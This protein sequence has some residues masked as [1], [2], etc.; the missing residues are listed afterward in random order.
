MWID[1]G[2]SATISLV[3]RQAWLGLT[4]SLVLAARD[5]RTET[6]SQ[7]PSETAMLCH[8]ALHGLE[9]KEKAGAMFP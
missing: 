6:A 7:I 5:Q 4:G 2:I 3:Y 8:W 1:H 9:R